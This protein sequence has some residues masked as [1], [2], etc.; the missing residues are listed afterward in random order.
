M[1]IKIFTSRIF[2]I[3]TTLL[4]MLLIFCMSAK[5]ANDSSEMSLTVGRT[6][7]TIFVPEYE[8]FSAQKQIEYAEN[9][10]FPI[11]KGAHVFEYAVLGFLLGGAFFAKE[12]NQEI[13][14]WRKRAG[15]YAFG[16]GVLY[17]ITDEIHQLFVPGRA[18]RIA[19]VGIDAVGVFLG[20]VIIC[21]VKLNKRDFNQI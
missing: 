13:S 12:K 7:C 8:A 20:V 21:L 3:L 6:I 10:E 15:G 1:L 4:W 11:R 2:Y 19:D 17:A 18:G 14:R 16:L 5:N 9:I